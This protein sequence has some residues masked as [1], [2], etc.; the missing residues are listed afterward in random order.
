MLRTLIVNPSELTGSLMA[1]ALRS[2]GDM[3]VVDYY[4]SCGEALPRI[5]S[6]T[7]DILLTSANLPEQ[8]LIHLIDQI[9]REHSDIKIVVTDCTEHKNQVLTYVS[10]GASG[11]ICDGTSLKQMVETL[12]TIWRG[13]AVVSPKIAAAI[14]NRI[15]EL[16]R[17][18]AI[19]SVDVSTVSELTRRQSEI[20][21]LVAKGLSNLEIA[22]QLYIEVGTVKNHVHSILKK[23][24]VSSRREA[25]RIYHQ[26]QK[27][28][29]ISA[30]QPSSA[31]WTLQEAQVMQ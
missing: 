13:E 27:S 3:R 29:P 16:S 10:A 12:R 7:C 20:L 19:S 17:R 26:A 6:H 18:S 15:A 31:G 30:H 11:Y 14:M 28:Q 5:G 21:T 1:A 24:D 22:E 9:S 25:A 2:E 8:E 23:L 4:T